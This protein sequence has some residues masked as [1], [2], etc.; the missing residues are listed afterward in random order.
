[1]VLKEKNK[2][3][4]AVIRKRGSYYR[5]C[6]VKN[7]VGPK[8]TKEQMSQAI[9]E[10]RREILAGHFHS[11]LLANTALRHLYCRPE[12]KWCKYVLSEKFEEQSHYVKQE[13]FFLLKKEYERLTSDTILRRSL[14]GTTTNQQESINSTLW[15][16]IP[17]RKYH[18]RMRVELAAASVVLNWS[19]GSKAHRV[20]LEEL[21]VQVG[22]T[23]Q[24]LGQEKDRK[25]VKKSLFPPEKTKVRKIKDANEH[26][27]A[28]AFV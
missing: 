12:D 20:I 23:S 2:L 13:C 6:I 8:V 1:M 25:R 18:G 19:L 10:T 5:K 7:K 28:G 16:R 14:R 27:E 4:D 24:R 15:S 22:K 9:Q 17:K 21:G 3:T 26:Y 11:C